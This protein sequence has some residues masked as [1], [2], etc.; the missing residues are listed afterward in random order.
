MLIVPGGLSVL[1]LQNITIL[2]HS[3]QEL[4]DAHGGVYGD[5]PACKTTILQTNLYFISHIS[6]S[7]AAR[8]EETANAC[9]VTEHD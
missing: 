5:F 6:C 3:Y 9:R 1:I 4:V 7:T 2:S 8:K